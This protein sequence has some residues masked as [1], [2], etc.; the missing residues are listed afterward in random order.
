[1]G[2]VALHECILTE[3]RR[4]MLEN[5]I[6]LKTKL[7]N[8]RKRVFEIKHSEDCAA[9]VPSSDQ[10]EKTLRQSIAMARLLKRSSSIAGKIE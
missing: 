9:A 2:P 7:A 3:I 1:M 8:P 4:R 6:L 10:C 5:V